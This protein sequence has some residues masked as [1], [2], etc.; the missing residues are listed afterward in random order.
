MRAADT[1][2]GVNGAKEVLAV[3]F[4]ELT[5]LIRCVH[6]VVKKFDLSLWYSVFVSGR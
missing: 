3:D 6:R 1:D 4:D 5:D 2:V